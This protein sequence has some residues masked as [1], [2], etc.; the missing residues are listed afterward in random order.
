METITLELP[1][2]W[3][4]ALFYDDTSGFEYEDDTQFQ[5]FCDW[6]VKN[7][8]TSEPVDKEEEGHFATYHDA[9]R[10]GVLACNV[11][12]YTSWS[13]AAPKDERNDNTCAHNEINNRA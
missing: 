7:Y 8:G 9:K 5:A 13:G 6:A 11:S 3:A 2:H 10:F 1:D 4:T 12:T